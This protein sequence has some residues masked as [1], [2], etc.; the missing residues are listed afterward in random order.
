M[1][2]F[3][4]SAALCLAAPL[5]LAGDKA[6][7]KAGTEKSCGE[8]LAENAKY[9]RQLNKV[10]TSAADFY[11]AH[12]DWVG[13][14]DEASKAEHDKL[15]QLAKEHRALAQNAKTLADS[16]QASSSLP[17]ASHARPPTPE[18]RQAM[19]RLQREMRTFAQLLERGARENQQAL[20]A[21][22]RSAQGAQQ[23]TGGSGTGGSG[24]EPAAE[25]E[26]PAEG[27][28]AEEP[29]IEEAPLEDAP[30]E[31]TPRPPQ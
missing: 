8:K 18:V 28:P 23:G 26:A 17:A 4:L 13:T 25:E 15:V 24:T 21:M 22:T 1:K 19:E 12:A 29:P 27:A 5:A 7:A 11:Q 16:L 6:D 14:G 10:V 20:Q 3:I 30:P 9:P 31:D 2:R